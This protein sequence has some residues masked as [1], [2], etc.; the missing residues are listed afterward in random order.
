MLVSTVGGTCLAFLPGAPPVVPLC[1]QQDNQPAVVDKEISFLTWVKVHWSNI[2]PMK[3]KLALSIFYLSWS[4]WLWALKMTYW[5]IEMTVWCKYTYVDIAI[6]PIR[7]LNP[8]SITWVD[9]SFTCLARC[10]SCLSQP[11]MWSKCVVV[12]NSLLWFCDI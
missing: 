8:V 7:K 1:G 11:P 6:T 12:S 4:A 10:W 3:V 2:T 9:M 5:S